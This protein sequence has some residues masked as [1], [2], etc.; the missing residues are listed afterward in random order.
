MWPKHWYSVFGVLH[1]SGY[2]LYLRCQTSFE[3]Q[4]CIHFQIW[5]DIIVRVKVLVYDGW[6][7]E[8]DKTGF[9]S[10]GVDISD[11]LYMKERPISFPVVTMSSIKNIYDK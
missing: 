9:L 6:L 3:L 7:A 5:D 10:F 2:H 4:Y 8:D 11:W 1:R